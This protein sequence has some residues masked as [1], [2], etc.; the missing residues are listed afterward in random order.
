MSAIAYRIVTFRPIFILQ[1]SNASAE[2]K[3]SRM[4]R[5]LPFQVTMTRPRAAAPG[6]RARL[7]RH[8]LRLDLA[9]RL[10]RFFTPAPDRM[11]AAYAGSAEPLFVVA[12]EAGGQIL[13]VAEVHAH[14]ARPDAAEIAL[15]V[16]EEMRRRGVGW[17][18]FSRAVAECRRRGIEDVWV[19]YLRGNEAMRRIAD[20]AGFARVP[21][22]DPTTITAHLIDLAPAPDGRALDL[23]PR[24]T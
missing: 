4:A 3:E 19:V 8:L 10:N 9:S 16:D 20:R 22:G 21:G 11:I 7:A 1:C 17:T 14:A 13:G 15:S 2:T 6:W 18:L 12:A 23:A 5:S 24:P